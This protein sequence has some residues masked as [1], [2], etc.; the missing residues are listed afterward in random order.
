MQEDQEED[1]EVKAELGH[2]DSPV[3]KQYFGMSWCAG[4]QEEEA[5]VGAGLDHRD[6]RSLLHI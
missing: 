5:E 6:S 2:K 4:D 3:H 1:E